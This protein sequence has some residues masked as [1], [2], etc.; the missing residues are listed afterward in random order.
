[1]VTISLN[2]LKFKA[3]HGIHEEE[4]ILGNDYVVNCSVEMDEQ[5]AVIQHLDQTIN[6]QI[7]FE[8]IQTQM[9]IP[10]P[11]LE[12]LCMRT[13]EKITE[14]FP[15]ISSVEITIKKMYPPVP[16]FLGSSSVTW[17]KTC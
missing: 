17:Q 13:G 11:L 12:T 10:T 14:A 16:G 15:N 7:L 4:K 9:D 8:I 3:Y 5:V 1:M 6:Y 2:D